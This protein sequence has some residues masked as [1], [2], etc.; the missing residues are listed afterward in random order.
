LPIA[1]FVASFGTIMMDNYT[2]NRFMRADDLGFSPA[3]HE[4]EIVT[5]VFE[6]RTRHAERVAGGGSKPE[7]S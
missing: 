6:P 3:Q 7:I 4:A 2:F 5:Q 1:A